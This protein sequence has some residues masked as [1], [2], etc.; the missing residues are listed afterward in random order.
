MGRVF[1]FSDAWAR[2]HH[3]WRSEEDR[4]SES[5]KADLVEVPLGDTGKTRLKYKDAAIGVEDTVHHYAGDRINT[6]KEVPTGDGSIDVYMQRWGDDGSSRGTYVQRWEK[7]GE[8]VH[9]AQKARRIT[10]FG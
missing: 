7:I 1:S 10:S 9:R 6:L 5:G 3:R 8:G 2:H 4:F